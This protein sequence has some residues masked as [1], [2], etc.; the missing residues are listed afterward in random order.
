MKLEDIINMYGYVD[1]MDHVNG[2]IF[3]LKEYKESSNKE[4]GVPVSED[5]VFIGYAQIDETLLT[6]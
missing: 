6:R 2:R 3:H 5:G 4:L 1:Y